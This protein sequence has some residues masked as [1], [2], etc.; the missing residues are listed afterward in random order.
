M[1]SAGWR[2]T[3]YPPNIR[4]KSR[5]ALSHSSHR[6]P[7][8]RRPSSCRY[9]AKHDTKP[10]ALVAKEGGPY[11]AGTFEEVVAQT[12]PLSRFIYLYL[13]K[14]PN[15]PLDPLGKEFDMAERGS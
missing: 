3:E 10:V 5:A 14:W 8:W 1:T 2:R 4:P 7:Q 15:K 13:I 9:V 12:Y 6:G 11:F